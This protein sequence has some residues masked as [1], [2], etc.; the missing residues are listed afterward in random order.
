[1]LCD[2][3]NNYVCV[4]II[5]GVNTKTQSYMGPVNK[6]ILGQTRDQLLVFCKSLRVTFFLAPSVLTC[7]STN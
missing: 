2:N 3:N 5:L 4:H 6:A 7:T 1:M